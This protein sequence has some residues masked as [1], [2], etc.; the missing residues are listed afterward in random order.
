MSGGAIFGACLLYTSC[1]VA[2][3]NTQ[4]HR[5][6]LCS[7]GRRLAMRCHLSP[8][9]P[10]SSVSSRKAK[11]IVMSCNPNAV[12]WVNEISGLSLSN[13]CV[14]EVH[15]PIRTGATVNMLV[16]ANCGGCI[17]LCRNYD[18]RYGNIGICLLLSLRIWTLTLSM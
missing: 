8:S 16:F 2:I 9:L 12:L 14:A 18:R 17:Q 5:I 1:N 3:Y 15:S 10:L 4:P 11:E 7:L 13:D 6:T